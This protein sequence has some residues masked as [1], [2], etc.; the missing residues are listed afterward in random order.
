[1]QGTGTSTYVWILV[2]R[3]SGV[4]E[5]VPALRHRILFAIDSIFCLEPAGVGQ[6][7]DI[8]AWGGESDLFNYG[9]IATAT[10]CLHIKVVGGAWSARKVHDSVKIVFTIP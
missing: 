8:F 6:L 2:G 9:V 10:V 3:A 5:A 4:V 7:C 1:M